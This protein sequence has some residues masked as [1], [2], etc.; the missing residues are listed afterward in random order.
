VQNERPALVPTSGMRAGQ[1]VE[2]LT[3]TGRA[4]ELKTRG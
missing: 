4:I 1:F 2:E 3:P